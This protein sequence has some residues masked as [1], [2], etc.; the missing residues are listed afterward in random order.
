MQRQAGNVLAMRGRY[1]PRTPPYRAVTMH[2]LRNKPVGRFSPSCL[3]RPDSITVIG[4][5]SAGRRAGDGQ[6]PLGGFKGTLLQADTVGRHRGAAVSVRSRRHRRRRRRSNCSRRWPPRARSLPSLS[7]MRTACPIRRS[8][9]A[10]ACWDRARSA[11]PCPRIGLNASRA[12]LVPPAGRLGLVSQSASLCRTVLDWAGPNGVGF[13]HIVGIG[14]PCGHRLRPGAGLAVAR[15]RDRRDPARYQAVAESPR[16][17]LRGPRRVAAA[18]GG[19]DPCGQ[20]RWRTRA[21]RTER[22]FEAAL[23]RAGVLCVTNLEDLLAAAEILARARPVR[24]E[25]LSIVTNAI[26]RRPDGRGRGAA[27]WA[28]ACVATS[29]TWSR[30]IPGIWRRWRAATRHSRRRRRAGGPCAIW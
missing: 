9:A 3:F 15:P 10:C 23:R 18:A 14:G 4:A 2:L 29:F 1:C 5:G 27:Q 30:T 12:H 19:G 22:A 13:S 17:P 25:A 11:S 24:S 6:P 21:A 20:R 8:A 28:A 26:S 7:A 16:V